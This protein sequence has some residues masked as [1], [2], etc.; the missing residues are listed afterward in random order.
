MFWRAYL[1]AIKA[2]TTTTTAAAITMWKP[3]PNHFK[4]HQF[5]FSKLNV[6][7]LRR[8]RRLRRLL[9]QRQQI[10]NNSLRCG[11]CN[12]I[13]PSQTQPSSTTRNESDKWQT[14]SD[15]RR[16]FREN[17][18]SERER[19]TP[20]SQNAKMPRRTLP[21]RKNHHQTN[22][23]NQTDPPVECGAGSSPLW[24]P[25]RMTACHRQ[26]A[27]KCLLEECTV[28]GYSHRNLMLFCLFP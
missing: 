17:S 12:D 27:V 1:M 5:Q 19:K 24:G 20:K 4:R 21:L 13:S 10:I 25:T 2:T 22:R 23:K 3:V 15:N 8:L 28:W 6:R 9:G 16:I 11:N 7:W 14:T 18:H 26:K